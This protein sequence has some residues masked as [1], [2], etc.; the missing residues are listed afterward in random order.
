MMHGNMNV[1]C[2]DHSLDTEI[3]STLDETMSNP[4]MDGL[5]VYSEKDVKV[6]V[7]KSIFVTLGICV[8]LALVGMS[9]ALIHA[10]DRKPDQAMQVI[11][12]EFQTH[13]SNPSTGTEVS[14][15]SSKSNNSDRE[16][17]YSSYCYEYTQLYASYDLY[18][19]AYACIDGLYTLGCNGGIPYYTDYYQI[20]Y[21]GLWYVE[22]Y[23]DC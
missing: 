7:R 23:C 16:L 22:C 18:D 8:F 9:A 10:R 1:I 15:G 11:A 21:G 6:R 2:K 19:A 4:E 17:Y 14:D 5:L 20:Y 3:P 12:K 13:N